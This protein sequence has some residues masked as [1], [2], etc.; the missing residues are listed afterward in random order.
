M[1][2]ETRPSAED[3]IDR[4][5]PMLSRRQRLRGVAAL[6]TGLSGAA[7][8]T[9]LWTTE[10]GGLPDRTQLAFALLTLTCLAWSGYGA[11]LV[12]R[13]APL[14]ALDRV[15]AGW[16]AL[17]A[18]LLTTAVTVTLAAIRDRGLI[19]ALIVGGVLITG[20]ALFNVRAHHKRRTLLHR[21]EELTAQDQR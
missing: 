6:L 11:W 21:K 9:T 5:A 17:A 18:A 1:T 7:F 4:L 13:R 2:D 20:T 14:F 15:I 16:L 8:V 19:P 3:M 10:P 12:A